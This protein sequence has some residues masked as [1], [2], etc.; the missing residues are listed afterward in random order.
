VVA[1]LGCR[2]AA[3]ISRRGKGTQK[4]PGKGEKSAET[5]KRCFLESDLRIQSSEL[6]QGSGIIPPATC[7][8]A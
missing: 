7:P 5:G 4:G 1:Y 3:L 2:R 6:P 8:K